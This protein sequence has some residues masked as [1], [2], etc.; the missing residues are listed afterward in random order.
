MWEYRL[1]TTMRLLD[2]AGFMTRA[3]AAEARAATPLPR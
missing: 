3:K 2:P 1:G